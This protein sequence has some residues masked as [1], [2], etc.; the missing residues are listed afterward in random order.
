MWEVLPFV[1]VFVVVAAVV[2]EGT[3]FC[4]LR[5]VSRLLRVASMLL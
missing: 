4:K 2:V 5:V 1:I 3:Y